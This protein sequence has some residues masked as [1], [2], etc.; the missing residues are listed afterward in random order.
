[1]QLNVRKCQQVVDLDF[2]LM[3]PFSF[4]YFKI[5]SSDIFF[6]AFPKRENNFFFNFRQ[7]LLTECCTKIAYT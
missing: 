3:I 1:M 5:I 2:R 6:N 4:H 7:I